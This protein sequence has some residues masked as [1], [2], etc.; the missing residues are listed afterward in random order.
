VSVQKKHEED[1][2]VVISMHKGT[3]AASQIARVARL[4]K[5]NFPV[6]ND[7]DVGNYERKANPQCFIFNHKGRL[8]F[9]PKY[10]VDPERSAGKYASEAPHWLLMGREF[11]DLSA[12]AKLVAKMRDLGKVWGEIG[13]IA[14]GAEGKQ[15]EEADYL[16]GRLKWYS[17]WLD[18]KAKAKIEDGR[19]SEALDVYKEM[20]TLF[21]GHEVAT[22]AEDT[23]A[24][25]EADGAFK[26]ELAAE[27][28]VKAIETAFYKV[29]P[30]REGESDDRW[31]KKYGK[32]IKQVRSKV[33]SM[34]KKYADTKV[35]K[36]IHELTK[37]MR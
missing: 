1:G 5:W 7:G 28:Q 14:K 21:R 33:A 10:G 25:C 6:Y 13:E 11:T 30:P 22:K 32:Y 36:R 15:K 12:K 20:A 19:P 27:K 34:E 37:D 17:E 23:K 2:L 35:F 9:D 8:V 29:K 26:K 3:G 18:A 4:K 16:L 24:K 31:R